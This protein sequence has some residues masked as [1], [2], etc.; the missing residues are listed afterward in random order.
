MSNKETG[1]KGEMLAAAYLIEKGYE[2]LHRNW[3]YSHAEVDI[4]ASRNNRLHFFE[5]KTR[6]GTMYGYP[7]EGFNKKKMQQLKNAAEAYQYQYPQWQYLQFDILSIYIAPGKE[8]DYFLIEDVY[9]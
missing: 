4:I 1:D 2:L 7:E 8:P 5:I 3:R 6:T 9:F